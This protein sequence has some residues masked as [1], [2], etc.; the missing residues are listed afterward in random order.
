MSCIWLLL[1]GEMPEA[2]PPLPND[3]CIIA[4]DGGMQIAQKFALNVDVHLGDGDS[5]NL[6][7]SSAG[8]VLRF[9]Q[10][11]TQTDF[12]LA[13]EF[14]RQ[15]HLK[16]QVHIFGGQ[17]GE[18]DHA[19]ANVWVLAQMNIPIILH[20]KVQQIIYLPAHYCLQG[21]GLSGAIMSI[22]ALTPIS[23]LTLSG[24]RWNVQEEALSP[25]VGYCARNELTATPFSVHWRAGKGVVFLPEKDISCH[26]K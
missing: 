17:G 12:E 18:L 25:F 3:V 8:S 21:Q 7:E 11:K 26:I 16:A 1:A 13:L 10:E 2:L 19:F 24:L 4:V 15:H 22:F 9:P 23:G 14:I 5:A 6:Y 20:G